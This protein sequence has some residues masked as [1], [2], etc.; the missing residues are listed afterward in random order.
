MLL[1]FGAGHTD[2]IINN[3]NGA[4]VFVVFQADFQLTVAFIQTVIG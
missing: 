2:A 1:N 3:G 4:L